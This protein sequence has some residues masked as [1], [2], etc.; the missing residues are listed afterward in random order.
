MKTKLTKL[1]SLL[2]AGLLL[3]PTF[4]A[5]GDEVEK[6]PEQTSGTGTAEE[7]KS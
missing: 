7:T 3:L 5:C 1:L 2:M 6:N 4:V